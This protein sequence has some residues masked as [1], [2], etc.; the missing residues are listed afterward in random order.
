[1]QVRGDQCGLQQVRQKRLCYTLHSTGD[2]ILSRRKRHAYC[3]HEH[4]DSCPQL[5]AKTLDGSNETT[6]QRQIA[7]R[8]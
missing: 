1:M 6:N 2:V 3:G 4:H 7:C 5:H 8:T